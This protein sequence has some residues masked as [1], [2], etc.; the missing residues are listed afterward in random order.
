MPRF[1]RPASLLGT[2]ARDAADRCA[3][4][5]FDGR[6]RR[7]AL[8]EPAPGDRSTRCRNRKNSAPLVHN[9]NCCSARR[10]APALAFVNVELA[11][12][13]RAAV[14]CRRLRRP[15]NVAKLGEGRR[16]GV[17]IL[18]VLAAKQT[19]WH[20]CSTSLCDI[21]QLEKIICG[22]WQLAPGAGLGLVGLQKRGR[23]SW[24]EAKG[25]GAAQPM[26]VNSSP[27]NS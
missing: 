19:S 15:N 10:F 16:R 7:E 2:S 21:L 27:S 4:I 5:A 14:G 11:R 13:R 20:G 1:R 17:Q 3:L 18:P 8:F 6:R 9:Q 26:H 22:T 25:G 23:S 24:P 12:D